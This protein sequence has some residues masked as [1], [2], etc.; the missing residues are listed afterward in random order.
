MASLTVKLDA[1]SMEQWAETLSTRGIRNAIRRAVDK[2]ATAARKVALEVIAKDAGVPVARIRPGV[3][4]V[5]RTTQYDLSASFTASKLRIGILNTQGA[6][7]GAGGL[8]ASTFRTTGGGSAKLGVTNA[9]IVHANGG[10]FVAIRRPGV[11]RLPI[12]GIYAEMPSTAMG[13]DDGAARVA[14][15]KEANKQLAERLPVEIAKQLLAE[16]L[17]YSPPADSDD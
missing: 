5:K 10:T 2:S 16:G 15:Q 6:S 4:K 3:T 8:T 14:W 7:V 12:K 9:F 11:K 1:A 13:Q 17:P